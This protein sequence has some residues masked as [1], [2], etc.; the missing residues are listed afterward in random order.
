MDR[1]RL[2]SRE[3]F[4]EYAQDALDSL[5]SDLRARMSNVGIVVEDEPPPGQWLLG[6]YQGV[7]LTRR[8]SHYGGV[9]PDKITIYRGP[10]VRLYARDPERLR[11]ELRRVVLHEVATTPGSATS[12][13]SKSTVT[14]TAY[15]RAAP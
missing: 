3:R 4:E 2:D 7:P 13:R 6:L 11:R 1:R 9:L 12:A 15:V 14:E 10:L 8:G 5:P